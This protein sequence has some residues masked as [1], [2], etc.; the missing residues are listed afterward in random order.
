[1]LVDKE[2]TLEKISTEDNYI[3]EN[4]KLKFKVV[5][6]NGNMVLQFI[7][8]Q[9]KVISSEIIQPTENTSTKVKMN[10]DYISKYNITLNKVDVATNDPLKSVQYELYEG[11]QLS[12][13]YRTDKNGNATFKKLVPGIEYTLKETYADGYYLN[14]PVKFKVVNTDGNPTISILS[15]NGEN[16]VINKTN[17]DLDEAS[18]KF[19]DIKAKRYSIDITKY[20][21]GKNE[22]L[23]GAGFMVS[24]NDLLTD[25]IA[26]TDTNGHTIISGLYEYKPGQTY[27]G[28]YTIE[29]IAPP[30]GYTR[31]SGKLKIKAQRNTSGV[32]E[33]SVIEDTLTRNINTG[34]DIVLEAADTDNA[35]YKIGVEDTPL[36][37]II[38]TDAKTGKKLPKTKFAIYEVDDDGAENIA[39]DSKGNIVGTEE[40][41]NGVR[42]RVVETDENGEYT[43]GLR[44]GQ[45]KFVELSTVDNRYEISKTPIYVGVGEKLKPKYGWT[46]IK[47]EPEN[48]VR[49]EEIK[50]D[51]ESHDNKTYIVKETWTYDNIGKG[52]YEKNWEYEIGSSDKHKY[53][54]YYHYK[55]DDNVILLRIDDNKA[56]A[57]NID[58]GEKIKEIELYGKEED[59]VATNMLYNDVTRTITILNDEYEKIK[60]F[61]LPNSG[62][63]L[64]DLTSLRSNLKV[65]FSKIN[66]KYYIFD[67]YRYS[68]FVLVFEENG[69]FF[70]SYDE[71][72]LINNKFI[73]YL[74]YE[75]NYGSISESYGRFLQI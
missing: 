50:F 24:G 55:Y 33:V 73:A 17:E 28:E 14:E 71:G 30:E 75:Y 38:K 34:K 46:K 18:V 3:S 48:N 37:T 4:S 10:F 52:A 1:M 8:G 26:E 57:L 35:V 66:N 29:E 22:K 32:L 43:K 70:K 65:E 51:I 11:E 25:K 41:I 60:T 20:I 2:Y 27:S 69:D 67:N 72:R 19:T 15:G 6:N 13:I 36:F 12:R 39:Y 63:N 42:Y 54:S 44:P 56:V 21:K 61:V 47:K 62:E 16:L 59:L 23:P 49:R 74:S 9:N 64:P 7:D 45:Y 68:S 31:N 5:E 58:T 40:E 53:D